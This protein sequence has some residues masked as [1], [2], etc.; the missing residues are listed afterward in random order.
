VPTYEYECKT[1]G[2]RFEQRQAMAEAPVAHCP[3]CAGE[4]QR[5]V[6][7]G[8]GFIVKGGGHARS[9]RGGNACSFETSGTTCCGRDARCGKSSCG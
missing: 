7:G 8:A 1:C 5:L 6:S 9:G 4:V 3:D 2:L